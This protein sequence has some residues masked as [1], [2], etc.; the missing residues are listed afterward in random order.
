MLAGKW[1]R[2]TISCEEC[3]KPRGIYSQSALSPNQELESLKEVVQCTCGSPI[4]TEGSVP[5]GKVFI[6]TNMC[7]L[8]HI[9]FAYYACPRRQLSIF[10]HCASPNAAHDQQALENYKVVLLVC[11]TCAQSQRLFTKRGRLRRSNRTTSDY[12]YQ[13]QPHTFDYIYLCDSYTVGLRLSELQLSV[14]QNT[15]RSAHVTLFLAQAGKRRRD[16]WSSATGE[17]KAAMRMTFPNPTTPFSSSTG[18]RSWF[19]T[20]ELAEQSRERC[21]TLYYS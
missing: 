6:Q 1:L 8:D 2:A 13:T 17:S 15:W 18:F 7:C 20:S 9:E 4:R 19:T 12:F 5:H 10:C 16:H 3:Q 21:S 14:Y 11:A